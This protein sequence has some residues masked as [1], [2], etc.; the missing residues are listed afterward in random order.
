MRG[1][2]D[3]EHQVLLHNQKYKGRPGFLVYA[4]F[5]AENSKRVVLV[6]R[7]WVALKGRLQDL[8]D[9]PGEKEVMEL[10]GMV[11]TMPSVGLK[12]GLPDAGEMGWPRAVTYMELAWLSRETGYALEPFTLLQKSGK[13]YGLIRD[14]A[15]FSKGAEKMPP[16]K[17]KSYAFQWFSLAFTL[18]VIYLV[19]NFKKTEQDN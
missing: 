11:T 14:W 10:K 19:V 2:F 18:C 16:E 17:H 12:S 1:K 15:Y 5:L 8:P 4:P 9:L 6:T 13:K 3:L 7:G